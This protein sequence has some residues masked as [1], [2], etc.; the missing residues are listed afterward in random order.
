[1]A[2]TIKQKVKFSLPPNKLYRFYMD[3][4]L[5]SELIGSKA[6]V[7]SE[8]GS[9]FSAFNGDLKG[10]MLYI[11]SNKII[12]QTWRGHS[13]GK[14]QLDSILILV[15]NEAESGT[16][17]EMIHA[18]V[19]EEEAEGIKKGWSEYYWTPWRNYIRKKK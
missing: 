13:W 9:N 17:L 2:V 15:F 16:E 18:N 10:K 6:V 12:A 7:S 14:D 3:S 5:H 8:I 11:K 1:M 4:K 19:P